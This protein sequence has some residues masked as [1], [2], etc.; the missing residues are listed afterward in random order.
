MDAAAIGQRSCTADSS[1]AD[2]NGNTVGPSELVPSGKRTTTEPPAIASRIRF[3]TLPLENLRSRST[4]IVLAARASLPNSSHLATSRFA[5]KTQ[6]R[7]ELRTMISRLIKKLLTRRPD[8]GTEPFA[9]T[10]ISSTILA[11]RLHEPRLAA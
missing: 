11:N 8:D 7:I 3:T 6:G 2:L 5:T 9:L 4:K 1:N 10:L